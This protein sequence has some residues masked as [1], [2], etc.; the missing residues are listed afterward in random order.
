MVSAT[1]ATGEPLARLG[2]GMPGFVATTARR[3]AV[4]ALAAPSRR[5]GGLLRPGAP[6]G[7]LLVKF[8]TRCRTRLTVMVGTHDW[9]SFL[10][11]VEQNFGNC[12]KDLQTPSGP[13]R[14]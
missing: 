13:W 2:P 4:Y 14:A 9:R 10:I 5:L 11:E 12:A 3:M 8:N 6:E 1:D 7:F